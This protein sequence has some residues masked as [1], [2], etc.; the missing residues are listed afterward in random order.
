V[1]RGEVGRGVDEAALV[2]DD[3]GLDAGGVAE[4]EDEESRLAAVEEPE[5]IAAEREDLV[6]S[7]R[8]ARASAIASQ[9]R[10]ARRRRPP[11]LRGHILAAAGPGPHPQQDEPIVS[12]IHRRPLLPAT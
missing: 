6:A 9:P 3:P 5:P 8:R 10:S 4:V 12:D 11:T 2:A 1:V 7:A